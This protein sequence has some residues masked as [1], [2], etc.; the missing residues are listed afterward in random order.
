MLV[1]LAGYAQYR[2][3]F[4]NTEV[5][6]I[7]VILLCTSFAFLIPAVFHKEKDTRVEILQKTSVSR[8]KRL[9]LAK[10]GLLL[11]Y[12]GLFWCTALI[13]VV[14]K[15]S[16]TYEIQWSAPLECLGIYWESGIA[17]S[18]RAAWIVGVL[19]QGVIMTVMVILLS[20]CAKRV[21]NQYVMTGILLGGSVV[22]T[23]LA[24]YSTVGIL[25]WVH[26]FFFVFS[27]RSIW[28]I[29]SGMLAVVA[30]IV[31]MCR[32]KLRV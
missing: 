16:H 12:T 13:F 5:S 32:R 6:R 3:L 19:L 14:F 28:V 4:E 9:W 22:P 7:F 26:D 25:Q 30:A 18:I 23:V 2:L 21:K 27:A 31:M 17:C 1:I 8:E 10:I 20:A 15:V 11:I 24:P 29:G